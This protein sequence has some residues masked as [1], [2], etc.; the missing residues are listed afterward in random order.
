MAGFQGA[1]KFSGLSYY[2]ASKAA[3]G[4]L[5]ECLAEEL[6]EEGFKVNALAIGS[7]QTEMLAQAFPGSESP[8]GTGTD[9]RIYEMVHT[10][11]GVTI[12]TERFCRFPFQ[13][14][15]YSIESR[16][17]PVTTF[18]LVVLSCFDLT[19]KKQGPILGKCPHLILS[20]IDK[21]RCNETDMLLDE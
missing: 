19:F 15:D 11:K 14:P 9:G 1:S 7:V 8:P 13:P 6:K 4:S 16:S 5:T 12:L 10:W 21:N 18:S 20:R 17:R 2:S 3:L